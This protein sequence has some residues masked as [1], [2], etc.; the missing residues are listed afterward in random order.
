[1]HEALGALAT[2]FGSFAA[3]GALLG[4]AVAGLLAG[5]TPGVSGRAGLLLVTPIAIGLGPTAGSI[6]LIAFHSVVHTSG[7]IPAILLGAPT[8]AAEAATAIDG[9]AMTRKGDA[10]RAIG[11]ALS[12]SAF[13]GAVGALFLFLAVPGALAL[14]AHIGTPEIAAL[15]GLGLLSIAALSGGW[16]SGGLMVAAVGLIIACV[17]VDPFSGAQ[18]FTF[19]LLGLWDGVN[20]AALVTGLFVVPE[21][22]ARESEPS[23]P[24]AG[25][26]RL[27]EVWQG[28]VEVASHGWL[29]LR[30]STIGALVGMVPG[31]GASAA[32]WIAYGHARQTHPSD[33]PYGEGAIA[34][35]IAPEAANN[36]KEG[37]SLIPTLFLGIPAS[38]GMGI[39][40]AAF[41]TLG[42]EV[43]PR[44]LTRSPE[45]VFL[46]GW[47]NIGSNLLALPLCFVFAPLMARFASLQRR[48]VVPV[49]LAAAL[50]ATALTDAGALTV[51]QL[52]VFSGLG[53]LLKS[54]NLP[55]APLV[56]GYVLGPGLES[57][58]IRSAEV[59]GWGAL[60]RPGV[61]TILS[62]AL[63]IIVVSHRA[64]A[65]PAA[66]AQ[67]G[68]TVLLLPTTYL[69]ILLCAAVLATAAA[70]PPTAAGLLYLSGGL[71]MV[72]AGITVARFWRRRFSAPTAP[73]IDLQ[74]LV[75]FGG[76]LAATASISLPLA[77]AALVGVGLALQARVG[78]VKASLAALAAATA[79]LCLEAVRR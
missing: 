49:A 73:P 12:A 69:V 33:I 22:T 68:G 23:P 58:L 64:R 5:L 34:G 32:V 18:R 20:P 56:L 2:L 7:S 39:L 1:M 8:S 9:Y 40:L 24:M 42:V 51:I 38:S 63:A 52:A 31:L 15:S 53:L 4:G 77:A 29:L 71:G 72:M 17:G 45:F 13:G 70:L 21:L 3:L 67:E 46:M 41:I 48:A 66:V 59:Y 37:G 28:C 44:M 61:L 14:I 27:R 25:Q 26:T 43:G 36:A 54:A 19:G 78:Y 16:L 55:R 57:G 30:G 35:V 79:V 10:G 50:A 75:L 6:F 76:A 60:A 65:Q 47:A 62:A 11:A 74:L